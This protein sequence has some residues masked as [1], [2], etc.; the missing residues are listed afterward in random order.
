MIY[1]PALMLRCTVA[2]GVLSGPR[3]RPVHRRLQ[4]EWRPVDASCDLVDAK[5]GSSSLRKSQS[6]PP[7]SSSGRDGKQGRMV[8]YNAEKSTNASPRRERINQE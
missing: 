3:G 1:Q 5:E 8:N 7:S 6:P 4:H 2:A